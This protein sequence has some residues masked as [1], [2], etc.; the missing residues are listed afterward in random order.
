MKRI[1]I[2]LFLL[3]CVTTDAGATL[4]YRDSGMFYDDHLNVTWLQDANYAKTSGYDSDGE[5]TWHAAMEWADGLSYQGYTDWALPN[6]SDLSHLYYDELGN[7]IDQ[8]VPNTGAFRNVQIYRYWSRT[9][10]AGGITGSDEKFARVLDFRD[11]HIQIDGKAGPD[12]YAW[13]IR[14]GD[15]VPEPTTILLIGSGL[16][17]LA[18]WR[19]R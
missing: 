16:V 1:P 8:L 15:V 18:A 3:F 12:K 19:R 2:L 4:V 17:C 6:I 10:D 9:S 5:M 13:A 11:G 14:K 7:I